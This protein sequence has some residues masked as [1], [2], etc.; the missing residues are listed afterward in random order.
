[1]PESP[2][3]ASAVAKP[4]TS[5]LPGPVAAGATAAFRRTAGRKGAS[6]GNLAVETLCPA[7]CMTTGRVGSCIGAGGEADD[8]GEAVADGD[9]AV[10]GE[11]PGVAASA[12]GA[13]PSQRDVAA[14]SAET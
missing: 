6:C 13:K 9:G 4:K 7:S 5:R 11:A 10:E 14:T 3:E 2:N 1:M 8:R 12:G